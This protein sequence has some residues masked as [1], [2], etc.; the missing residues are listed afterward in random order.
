MVMVSRAAMGLFVKDTEFF[1][2]DIGPHR[3]SL[4]TVAS[5][6]RTSAAGSGWA[7]PLP[8][9]VS[10]SDSKM[11]QEKVSE[12]VR[13]LVR[14]KPHYGQ[15]CRGGVAGQQGFCDRYYDPKLDNSQLAK[16]IR[17]QAEQWSNGV[18][19]G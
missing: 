14:E 10:V 13:Q 11:D 7:L 9:N 4:G 16:A 18:G 12:L 15:G 6:W 8:A 3:D 5:R 17:Y 19:S 1:G 2:L